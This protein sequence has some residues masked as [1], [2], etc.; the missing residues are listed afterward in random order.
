MVRHQVLSSLELWIGILFQRIDLLCVDGILQVQSLHVRKRFTVPASPCFQEAHKVTPAAQVSHK[1]LL[2]SHHKETCTVR[3]VHLQSA[4]LLQTHHKLSIKNGSFT[5]TYLT[6]S[7]FS[8]K[9][10]K[11]WPQQIKFPLMMGIIGCREHT[12]HLALTQ[13]TSPR[14]DLVDD[15]EPQMKEKQVP[16]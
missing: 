14:E 2:F 13:P 4:R 8:F 1:P 6:T 16:P 11:H 10:W 15:E 5:G 3:I 7:K 9:L 12:L